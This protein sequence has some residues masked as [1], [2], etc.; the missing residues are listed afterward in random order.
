[1]ILPT[2]PRR[3]VLACWA[4]VH[5]IVAVA[6]AIAITSAPAPAQQPAV[7]LARLAQPPVIDG[8]LDEA[9]WEGAA[10]L[11]AFVQTWPGDNT[12][13]SLP[14]E[15]RLGHDGRTLYLAIRA[16]DD[17]AR[18]RSSMAR[19]DAIL[20]DDH[21]RILLDTFGDRR[22]AYLLAFNPLGVPQDGI[23]VEGRDPDYSADL[24]ITS[25]G[26]LDGLGWTV[27][28]AI[29]LQSL[30]YVAGPDRRWGLHVQRWS[31]A[32]DEE[33]SWLPLVRGR[34][35]LL[36]QAGT[37]QGLDDL[38]GGRPV[39]VIPTITARRTDRRVPG[40]APAPDGLADGASMVDYGLSAMLGVTPTLTANLAVNPD[41]AQVE[42]DQ[43]VVTANQR[44][45][46]L[47]EEK[48]P[49][50]LEGAD[51]FQT[52]LRV[53]HTR[54]IV[55]PAATAKL[56]GRV[57]RAAVGV[58]AARDE[59]PAD[60]ADAA[61]GDAATA[62]TARWRRDIGLQSTVGV[63]A[64]AYSLGT[65]RNLTAG[66][67]GRIALG[68][69]T[70]LAFEVS[71][72]HAD[73][74]FYDPDR[75]ARVE[76]TGRGLGYYVDA[77]RTGRHLSFTLNGEGRSPDWVAEIGYTR[78]VNANT[79]SLVTSYD[80]EPRSG[81]TL[82]S[83]SLIHTVLAQ[84]DWQ[85]RM[86]YAYLYPRVALTFPR[87][88]SVTVFAYV[89]YLRLLEE[90][91]GAR[92][93]AMRPGAFAGPPER[94]TVL[95]GLTLQADTTPHPR[96]TATLLAD[97][98]WR[99]FDYDFGAGP[100]YPRVSPAA[101]VDPTAPL[102]P[103]TGRSLDVTATLTWRVSGGLRVSVEYVKSRLTRDDTRRVAWNENLVGGRVTQQ[104]G[105]FAFVRA[106]AD[107]SS[108]RANLQAEVVGGWTPT[109]GTALYL[110]YHDD[111]N[112]D[113]YS[114]FTG[115]PEGGWSRNARAFFAKLSYAVRW[116]M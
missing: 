7:R 64:T 110:G 59:A 108:L 51:V 47:F 33:D 95:R 105:R 53:V 20:D 14:T 113:G 48:R 116:G 104:L 46:L 87:Q 13:P 58:L 52:P 1:M 66:L 49:F 45:A 94:R 24:P 41:F 50:F 11:G 60:L 34:A 65:R 18:V 88:T 112:H 31:R 71:G 91:F 57:G 72:S 69:R 111:V 114:P 23:W 54:A 42:A 82:I 15:V 36:G 106:R 2:M 55:L 30:R 39:E 86:K 102:D 17:P 109:P 5:S 3:R 97:R 22:R 101:L 67:D 29:P 19:R 96:L 79:W 99:I 37:V 100:R 84:W 38:A 89:D 28:A 90:E 107:W 78:Q 73:R 98:S 76:R 85:G 115:R 26:R 4:L 70:V 63:L 16:V 75:D 35:G 25:V 83:W 61:P 21:V 9:A 74:P 8:R 80:A 81:A 68:P 92:R 12:S 77:R 10:I 44:F 62:G 6:V 43:P 56:V 27:E 40:Q 103:G 32:R 93:S